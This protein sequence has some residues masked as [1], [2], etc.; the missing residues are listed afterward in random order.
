MRARKLRYL[1]C[2]CDCIVLAFLLFYESN[3]LANLVHQVGG[4]LCCLFAFGAF[5]F[6]NEKCKVMLLGC[7]VEACTKSQPVATSGDDLF[8]NVLE[9]EVADQVIESE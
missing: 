1:R 9:L 8:E 3:V 4:A 6:T 2:K 5:W 7:I